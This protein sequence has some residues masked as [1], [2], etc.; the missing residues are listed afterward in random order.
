MITNFF[1]NKYWTFE[2]KTFLQKKTIVQFLKFIGFSS[3]DALVQLG[4][5]FH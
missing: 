1:L 5:F 2:D 3:L 4:M